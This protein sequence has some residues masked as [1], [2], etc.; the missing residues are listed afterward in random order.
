MNATNQLPL[1]IFPLSIDQKKLVQVIAP[2]QNQIN[3]FLLRLQV[4]QT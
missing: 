1:Q 4:L 3:L 2:K